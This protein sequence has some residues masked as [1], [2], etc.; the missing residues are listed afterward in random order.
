MKIKILNKSLSVSFLS[1]TVILLL[2]KNAF[3]ANG[4]DAPSVCDLQQVF[5]NV[6]KVSGALLGFG[7]FAMMVFGGIKYLFSA[8]DPKAVQSAKGT[9][10]W[11][12]IGLA[13]YALSF[14]ILLL[15]RAFTGVDVTTFK[16]C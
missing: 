11:A 7:F 1:I 6:I 16:L 9:L 5:L 8:G 12:I 2:A 4:P 13:I 3:A 10:T 14:T 15:I